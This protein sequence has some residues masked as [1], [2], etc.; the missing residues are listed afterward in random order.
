MATPTLGQQA[1]ASRNG[2]DRTVRR[3]NKHTGPCPYWFTVGLRFLGGIFGSREETRGA[4]LIGWAA[5]HWL[6]T[7]RRPISVQ[8]LEDSR[9]NDELDNDHTNRYIQMTITMKDTIARINCDGRWEFKK[10]N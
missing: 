5:P 4:D 2:G 1:S 10:N 8:R 7:G 9:F 6:E 3:E